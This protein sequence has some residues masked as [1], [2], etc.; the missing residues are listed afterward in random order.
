MPAV[1]PAVLDDAIERMA[2]DLGIT[3]AALVDALALWISEQR[4]TRIVAGMPS[5]RVPSA[6]AVGTTACIIGYL[7]YLSGPSTLGAPAPLSSAEFSAEL[8]NI[9]VEHGSP[10]PIWSISHARPPR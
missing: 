1:D 3:R 4:I 9:A 6:A 8:D 10:G 2:D 7:G 5:P